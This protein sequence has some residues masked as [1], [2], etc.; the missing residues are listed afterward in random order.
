MVANSANVSGRAIRVRRQPRGRG[1]TDEHSPDPIDVEVGSNLRRARLAR[2]FTQ[3]ELGDALGMSFQ[4]I[5]KYERGANRVSASV[6]V[7][8]ARFLR[9]SAAD[10]LPPDDRVEPAPDFLHR[11]TEVRGL[12][13][14]VNAYCAVPS[15][16]LRVALL[17]LTRSL[18]RKAELAAGVPEAD[19]EP[20]SR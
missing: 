7:K 1:P 18:G 9:I 11:L 5:Q 15:P 4:Q 10:L 20:R 17:K 13:E 14:I 2:G 12:A 3:T 8:A 16:A 19:R 6:L